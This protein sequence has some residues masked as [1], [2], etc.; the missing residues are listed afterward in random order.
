MFFRKAK[1]IKRLNKWLDYYYQ[2]NQKDRQTRKKDV[3]YLRYEL[4]QAKASYRFKELSLIAA[5][6]SKGIESISYCEYNTDKV[7]DYYLDITTNCHGIS[8]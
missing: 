4:S 6:M 7:K 3:D 1:E 8:T 5:L 2:E